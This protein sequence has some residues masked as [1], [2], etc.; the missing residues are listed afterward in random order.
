M[1]YLRVANWEKWQSYRK[2]RGTPPW[3]KVYRNLL[4]N[5]DW[6]LLTDAEKGQLVSIWI[7]AAERS[8]QIPTDPRVL[9]KIAMLDD[10]PNLKKFKELGFLELIGCQ[11][12]NQVASSGCQDDRPETETESET[13]KS[14]IHNSFPESYFTK[15][16]LNDKN[17]HHVSFEDV[18]Q[19]KELYPA[20]DVEQQLRNMTGW[21]LSNTGKRKTKV[22][23][24]RFITA[25]LSREQDRGGNGKR[26]DGQNNF[27]H[28]QRIGETIE[29]GAEQAFRELSQG[30]F[31][32]DAS[33]ISDEVG[34]AISQREGI[35]PEY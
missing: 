19:Y 15:M 32:E 5:Q 18:K 22:G 14:Y 20:V 26:G 17:Y 27:S 16:I 6:S 21:C 35:D 23:I 24:R 28:R 11:D 33:N 9:R 12:D 13:D 10:E 4:S 7:L 30:A 25:W 34:S 31:P 29:A 8:G 1:K 2:D 3:I